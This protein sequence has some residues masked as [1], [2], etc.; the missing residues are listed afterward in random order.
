[1][2]FFPKTVDSQ[3]LVRVIKNEVS[4]EEREFFESWLQE[5][6]NHKEEFG[7]F[8]LLWDKI[9]NVKLPVPPPAEEQFMKIKS[10]IASLESL[11]NR[12]SENSLIF[13]L[14]GEKN[15]KN[16][17]E[18][19]YAEEEKSQALESWS[20][21]LYSSLRI[22]ASIAVVFCVYYLFSRVNNESLKEPLKQA[23]VS[24]RLIEKVNLKGER[25]TVLLADG[26]IVYLNSN[27][28]LLYPKTFSGPKREVE[29][30]GEAY[31]DV[32]HNRQQ[33]FIVKTGE[34]YT[35]VVGTEFDLK[36]RSNRLS[37]VVTQGK[38]KAYKAP[39]NS[40]SVP[41]GEMV[42]YNPANGFSTPVKVD[43]HRYTAWR[44]NKLSFVHAPLM[45]VMNEIENFYN[46]QVVYKNKFIKNKTLT[47]IFDSD[48][49]DNILS[50]V[51]LTM[52]MDVKREGKLIVVR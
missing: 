20:N 51:S 43:V 49:L 9:G 13:R 37:L 18:E 10:R 38:V 21:I 22:A 32:A 17:E 40:V 31:F 24:P 8:I 2:K 33:P 48:S 27:S 16:A 44:N 29:I 11:E 30:L 4:L 3:F 45:E 23:V 19:K 14:Q 39:D 26:T 52:E 50:M 42:S 46:V 12:K 47:G 35:E 28:R 6:E 36:Y 41:K 15:T 1:M 34:T 25:S 5:S 7:N